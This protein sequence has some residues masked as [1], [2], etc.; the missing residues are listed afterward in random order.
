M[1]SSFKSNKLQ[2]YSTDDTKNFVIDS[3]D[4][5]QVKFS[6]THGKIS[7]QPQ[8]KLSVY[9][10]TS[11]EVIVDVYAFLQSLSSA[12]TQNGTD[13]LAASLADQIARDS[14]I[15]AQSALDAAQQSAID[16][17]E[18]NAAA[19]NSTMNGLVDTEA[20]SRLAADVAQNVVITSNKSEFDSY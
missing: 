13:D 15:S 19:L 11:S 2:V 3:T 20:A 18:S 10:D 12:I 8:T 9:G 16:T 4:N 17:I 14:I 5:T 7:I 1:S 6:A